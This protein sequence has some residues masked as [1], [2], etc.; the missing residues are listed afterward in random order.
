MRVTWL[1][2]E[3]HMVILFSRGTAEERCAE[4][5]AVAGLY[6]E[7]LDRDALNLV[8]VEMDPRQLVELVHALDGIVIAGHADRVW[9]SYRL[10][11]TAL[12]ERI[13]SAGVDAVE[14]VQESSS[15]VLRGH[16]PGLQTLQASDSHSLDEVGQRTCTLD[17]PELRFE[18]LKLALRG[19]SCA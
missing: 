7:L 14:I 10:A 2:E 11:G 19:A 16:H 6:E 18:D 3:A 9:G 13:V 15:E 5:F 8:T 12:F 1:G 4:V 17:L